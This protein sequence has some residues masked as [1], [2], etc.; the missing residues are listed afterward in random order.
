MALKNIPKFNTI[1]INAKINSDNSDS[2]N[3]LLA[4]IL[5]Q[6]RSI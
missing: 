1:K 5:S 6:K 2:D 4:D 3:T